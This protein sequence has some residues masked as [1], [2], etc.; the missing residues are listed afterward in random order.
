MTSLHGAR[1]IR[2][3]IRERIE[4]WEEIRAAAAAEIKRLGQMIAIEE[5]RFA[6]SQATEV[7]DS[8]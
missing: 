2:P 3:D 1:D 4:Y 7:S 6:A 5:A 8:P